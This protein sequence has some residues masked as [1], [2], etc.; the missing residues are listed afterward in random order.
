MARIALN[1]LYLI[2]TAVGG[3]ETYAR[4]L[5]KSLAATDQ[6][7]E[8]Y[9][10]V[11]RDVPLSKFASA[12]NFHYIQCPVPNKIRPLR[13]AWEQ[14][15]LP[16][17]LLYYHIEVVHSLAY[18]GPLVTPCPSIITVPDLNF[19]NLIGE[20][21]ERRRRMLQFFSTNAARRAST[22]ITISQFSK[23]E[24]ITN[25]SLPE[26]K[27]VVTHL[28]PGWDPN[29]QISWEYIQQ[30]YEL[31]TN[32]IVAFGGGGIHK[33]IPQLIE[34]FKRISDDFPHALVLIGRI[35]FDQEIL[36]PGSDFTS[37]VISVGYVPIEHISS[38][39]AN[40]TLFVM[41]SLYEGFGLPILEAQQA[42]VAVASSTKGSLREVGGNGVVYFDPLSL[43]DMV[44][45]IRECLSDNLLRAELIRRG[46]ENLA[47]FS[48][49]QAARNTARI[50]ERV[51]K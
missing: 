37:R 39:L 7:N 31:P 8:Y 36:H 24:I 46:K 6:R 5:V 29:T 12:P 41:P 51:S 16:W 10:F 14:F 1:L 49:E 25:L 19:K 44:K 35:S 45:V 43:D 47:R 48:W 50:Y 20:I 9:I 38:I 23:T 4:M 21:P 42:G 40:A 3:V 18:V 27:I 32:Y 22:V 30:K 13:Y 17:Q 34:A 2:P 28:G 11:A 26:D 15:I 33:N